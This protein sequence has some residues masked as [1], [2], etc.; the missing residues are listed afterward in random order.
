MRKKERKLRAALTKR[1]KWWTRQE[2]SL[3]SEYPRNPFLLAAYGTFKSIHPRMS[4]EMLY[5]GNPYPSRTAREAWHNQS[6]LS[7]K[8]SR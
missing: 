6:F 2:K 4:Y 3:D 7:F 1:V 8:L 5:N